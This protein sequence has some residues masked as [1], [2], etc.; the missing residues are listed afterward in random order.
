MEIDADFDGGAIKVENARAA[1]GAELLLRPDT[2]AEFMQWFSFRARVAKGKRAAYRIVNAGEATYADAWEGY[3]VAASYDEEHWFRVP[4]DFDGSVLSF[5]HTPDQALVHYAYFA[6]YPL[7]RHERL[8][9][10]AA[11]SPLANVHVVGTSVQGRPM[12]VIAWGDDDGTKRKIWINARQHPGETMAEWFMEGVIERLLDEAD[13]LT[14]AL[15]EKACFY[16]VPN[17]NPDGGV[18]GNLRTNAAGA[19]LN[20]EW[21]EPTEE[22][23]PEV[24]AVRQKMY[25]T[26]VDLFF[27]VHGDERNPYIFAAGCEGNPSYDDR[28]DALEDTFMDSLIELDTDFQREY[29]YDRDQ[30]G[31]GDLTTAGNWVGETFACLSLTLE[32]PFKDNANHPDARAGWSPERAKHFGRTTL[33]S[34]YVT[35]DDLR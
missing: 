8:I 31:E 25:D 24:L 27:D 18:L 7:A 5:S 4:T 3:R 9:E 35:I 12:S 19:N 28:M 32:M 17:M 13:P 34:A 2:S 14:Q 21:V 10:R 30:P 15:L 33:E 11:V 1:S 6:P 29:G 16:L 22:N 20:R 26:G 23:S